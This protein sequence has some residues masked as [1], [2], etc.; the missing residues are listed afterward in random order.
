MSCQGVPLVTKGMI[1]CPQAVVAGE[2]RYVLPF[3]VK[4]LHDLITLRLFYKDTI[5]LSTKIDKNKLNL[6]N[7]SNFKLNKKIVNSLNLRLKK[8]ED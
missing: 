5:K 8:C 2:T 4:L 6:V 3:R 7:L 1:Y